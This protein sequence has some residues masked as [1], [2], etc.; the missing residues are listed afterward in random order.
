MQAHTHECKYITETYTHTCTHTHAHTQSAH[1][2][3]ILTH[4]HSLPTYSPFSRTHTVC[5]STLHSHSRKDTNNTKI[6]GHNQESPISFMVY[7]SPPPPPQNNNNKSS[8]HK[9]RLQE[10]LRKWTVTD[11]GQVE[12]ADG[13]GGQFR[14]VHQLHV[15]QAISLGSSWW[16]VLVTL[17]LFTPMN[18]HINIRSPLVAGWSS[19]MCKGG[20]K[21]LFKSW[22]YLS[23]TNSI[24]CE[25]PVCFQ[26]ALRS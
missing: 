4:T 8:C 13:V 17:D 23:Y 14:D 5:P 26:Q 20:W 3:S 16:P 2:F 24:L 6:S 25:T 12:S 15:H 18:H 21:M 19:N 1:L 7:P 22:Q 10:R 11:P 9:G